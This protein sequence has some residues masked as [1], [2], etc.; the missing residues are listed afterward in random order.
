M[1]VDQRVREDVKQ[2]LELEIVAQ[3]DKWERLRERASLQDQRLQ[4]Q[5]LA[6]EAFFRAAVK[7][8]RLV[9]KWRKL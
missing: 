1:N 5:A 6:E 7:L 9:R 4:E 8:G 3:A 2:R